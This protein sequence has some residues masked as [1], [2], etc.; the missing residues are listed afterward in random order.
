M[1]LQL[2]EIPRLALRLRLRW[3]S[4]LLPARWSTA[5]S[6]RRRCV[7]EAGGGP[8]EAPSTSPSPAST[9]CLRAMFRSR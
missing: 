1:R 6:V 5:G 2:H 9:C 3:G 7:Q 4:S 8:R